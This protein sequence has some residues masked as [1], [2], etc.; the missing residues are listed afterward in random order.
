[1]QELIDKV[2]EQ[3][4]EDVQ[5]DDLTAIEGMLK[6]VPEEVLKSFLPEEGA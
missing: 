2:L 1:M 3:V 5:H 4:V 6:S